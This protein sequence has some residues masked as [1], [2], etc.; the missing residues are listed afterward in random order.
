M[1]KADNI[2]VEGVV[3]EALPNANFKVKLVNDRI[4]PCFISGKLRSNFIKIVAGDKVKVAF[5][6]YDLTKGRIIWRGNSS[7]EEKT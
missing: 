2:E 1:S 4:V 6:P 7:K 3:T 5:S